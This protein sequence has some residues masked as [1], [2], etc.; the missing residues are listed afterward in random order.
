MVTVRLFGALRLD[1]K[2]KSLE[3]EAATVE[4]MLTQAAASL[5]LPDRSALEQSVVFV[6]GERRGRRSQL[7]DGDEVY[8]LSPMAG[9]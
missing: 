8:L 7:R 3:V 6:N 1:T 5:G 4:A 9:G 2:R